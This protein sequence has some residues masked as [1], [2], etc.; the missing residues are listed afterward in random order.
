M[1]NFQVLDHHVYREQSVSPEREAAWIFE[2][3]VTG[4][5]GSHPCRL[6]F[7]WPSGNMA[8]T[9]ETVLPFHPERSIKITMTA[10]LDYVRP[11]SY[12]AQLIIA[13]EK[14]HDFTFTVD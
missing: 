14:V 10:G 1:T 3:Y 2:F 13:G 4:Q 6:R 11:G 5:E 7:L 12:S 8:D 9:P